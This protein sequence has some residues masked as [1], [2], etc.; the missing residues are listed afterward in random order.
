MDRVRVGPIGRDASI[1]QLVEYDKGV[2]LTIDLDREKDGRWIAEALEI[3]GV[4]PFMMAA[5]DA[6]KRP[7][8]ASIMRHISGPPIGLTQ[9]R[10][11]SECLPLGWRPVP[12]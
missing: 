10:P 7:P 2:N 9:Q 4:M 1:I 5:F 8:L 11:G 12:S 3:P 6:P